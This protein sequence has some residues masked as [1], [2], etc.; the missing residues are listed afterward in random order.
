MIKSPCVKVCTLDN[1]SKICIACK[2]TIEEIMQWSIISD[3]DRSKILVDLKNR[4]ITKND[5]I[6]F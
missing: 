4:K 2:R 6:A 1:E 3:K 5:D